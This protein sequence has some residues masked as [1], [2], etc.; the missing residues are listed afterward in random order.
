[1]VKQPDYITKPVNQLYNITKQL[2]YMNMVIKLDYIIKPVEYMVNDFDYITKPIEY[3]ANKPDY[4]TK[5]VEY[6]VNQPD[7]MI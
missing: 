6:M 1:M 7:S 3:M 2:E 4:M 5:P